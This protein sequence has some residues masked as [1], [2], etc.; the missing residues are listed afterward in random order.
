MGKQTMSEER[1]ATLSIGLWFL[2]AIVLAALFIAS[3]AQGAL[4][5]AHVALASVILIL[6]TVGTI[7]IWRMKDSE[8]QSEKTKRRRVDSLID[9]L[10]DD[11]LAELK[12]R[13]TGR[14]SDR[15]NLMDYLGDDGEIRQQR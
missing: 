3:A 8:T 6:A 5:S 7:S 11:E 15:E 13:L 1:R 4:T 12:H 14:D 10:S 9:D 2:S